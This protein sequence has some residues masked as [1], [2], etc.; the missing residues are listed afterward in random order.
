MQQVV[1]EA[2]ESEARKQLQSYIEQLKTDRRQQSASSSAELATTPVCSP[3]PP[4]ADQ[5]SPA[6]AAMTT[7]TVTRIEPVAFVNTRKRGASQLE[8]DDPSSVQGSKRLRPCD[9]CGIVL[10]V[11][12]QD[13]SEDMEF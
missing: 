13:T 11:S 8:Y 6:C 1:R 12:P 5:Q 7:N 3:R 2:Q 4:A 10:P 9:D